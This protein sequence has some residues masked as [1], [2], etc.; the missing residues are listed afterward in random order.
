MY[1]TLHLYNLT[2]RVKNNANNI[3][4]NNFKFFDELACRPELRSMRVCSAQTKTKIWLF[5]FFQKYWRSKS[6]QT[7]GMEEHLDSVER[8]LRVHLEAGIRLQPSKKLFFWVRL[9]SKGSKC[10][11]MA[12]NWSDTLWT[13]FE[14][15]YLWKEAINHTAAPL[16]VQIMSYLRHKIGQ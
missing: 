9:I 7:L 3:N 6:V 13:H 11:E 16:S 5:A 15:Q 2:D 12:S 8:V 10:L 1:F 14:R 4:W